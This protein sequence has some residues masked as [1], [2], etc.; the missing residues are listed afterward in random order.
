MKTSLKKYLLKFIGWINFQIQSRRKIS[1]CFITYAGGWD[2]ACAQAHSIVSI[3]LF[4]K[5]FNLIYLH[6]PLGNVEHFKGE[7]GEWSKAWESLFS[8]GYDEIGI[9][10]IDHSVYESKYAKYPVLIRKKK[11]TIYRVS[12]CHSYTDQIASEYKSLLKGLNVKYSLNNK[13]EKNDLFKICLHIRRGD[14]GVNNINAF[15]YTD[16][17]FLIT[18]LRK[19]KSVLDSK[20]IK[21]KI[22]IFSEGYLSDFKDFDFFN[23]IFKL[24][25]DEFETFNS[26]V[27]ADLLIMAKS[28]FSYMAALLNDGIVFYES[29][30]HKPLKEWIDIKE[31][32]NF[33]SVL[34]H[35][36]I[37]YISRL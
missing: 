8:L 5:K 13:K 12:N 33:A 26:L 20:K 6:T 29:F 36:L 24:N 16:N 27:K 15:R 17:Q 21:H 32:N 2:G 35:K 9:D 25:E 7:R 14:V 31:E 22:Y 19:I 18:K 3:M 23:P 4:A 11:G 10:S 37:N 28:S 30:W 34:N 1:N